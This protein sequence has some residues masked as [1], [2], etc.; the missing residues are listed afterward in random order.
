MDLLT[1]HIHKKFIH[2]GDCL[3]LKYTSEY[4]FNPYLVYS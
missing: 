2:K 4:L 1:N 3:H